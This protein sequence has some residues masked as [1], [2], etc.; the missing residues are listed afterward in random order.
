VQRIYANYTWIGAQNLL[1]EYKKEESE[2]YI[3]GRK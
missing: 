3:K 1:E 2:S